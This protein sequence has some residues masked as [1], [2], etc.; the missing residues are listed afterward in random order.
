MARVN[1]KMSDVKHKEWFIDVLVS[2]IRQ[3][4]MQQNI[5]MQ[6]EALDMAMKL[7]ASPIG[8]TT[9]GMNQIQVQLANLTL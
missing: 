3:S 9:V 7:E 2:H 1:L 5:T 8:E 4:L 6:N